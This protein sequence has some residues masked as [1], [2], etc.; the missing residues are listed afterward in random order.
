MRKKRKPPPP[1]PPFVVRIKADSLAFG[2]RRFRS[3]G[4]GHEWCCRGQIGCG[5]V[6]KKQ[7]R[8]QILVKPPCTVPSSDFTVARGKKKVDS[9]HCVPCFR[10]SRPTIFLLLLCPICFSISIFAPSS[11]FRALDGWSIAKGESMKAGRSLFNRELPPLHPTFAFLS[12]HPDL[13]SRSYGGR[14]PNRKGPL[15]LLTD[16]FL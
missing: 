7:T 12:A 6:F 13:L 10:F 11:K 3:D 14:S 15:S 2:S 5:R 1:H 9:I 16:S 8:G 4:L